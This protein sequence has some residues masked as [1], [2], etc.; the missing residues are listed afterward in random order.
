M[1]R[2][3]TD[4]LV[5]EFTFRDFGAKSRRFFLL[6]DFVTGNGAVHQHADY[7]FDSAAETVVGKGFDR[8][9][10]DDAVFPRRVK[11]EFGFSVGGGDGCFFGKR[12]V[13]ESSDHFADGIKRFLVFGPG[14]RFLGNLIDISEGGGRQHGDRKQGGNH[15]E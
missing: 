11:F 15:V 12:I 2:V 1:V 10:C 6:D 14:D 5:G 9:R 3:E 13:V 4:K 7:Q 8:D